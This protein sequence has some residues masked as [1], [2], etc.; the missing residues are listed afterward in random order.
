MRQ[1]RQR[2]VHTQLASLSKLATTELRDSHSKKP[3]NTS[4]SPAEGRQLLIKKVEEAKNL[5]ELSTQI[6]YHT[7]KKKKARLR[8]FHSQL[9]LIGV[10]RNQ[11]GYKNLA[12]ITAF[13]IWR[14]NTPVPVCVWQHPTFLGD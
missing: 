9:P 12:E 7:W 8:F 10:F 6:N 1:Q 5:L 13:A 14:C 11:A 2:N 4:P 3:A